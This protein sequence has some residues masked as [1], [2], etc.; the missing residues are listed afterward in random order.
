MD[1]IIEAMF[2]RATRPE[3]SPFI[4]FSISA[5]VA[6]LTSSLIVCFKQEAAIAKSRVFWSSSRQYP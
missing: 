4:N 2:Y 5:I 6:K 3:E 1:I